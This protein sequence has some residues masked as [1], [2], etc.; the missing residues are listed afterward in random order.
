MAVQV[1]SRPPNT[2]GPFLVGTGSPDGLSRM[3][4]SNL[5]FQRG[6]GFRKPITSPLKN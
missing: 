2:S 4:R 1:L 6:N 3:R 5:H